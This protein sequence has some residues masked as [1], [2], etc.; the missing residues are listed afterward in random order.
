[1]A[2]SKLRNFLFASI[3]PSALAIFRIVFGAFM[4][5]QTIYYL[6]IDYARQFMSGPEFLF[7]YEGLA[8]IKP[9]SYGI[10]KAIN[11]GMI[12]AA[13]LIGLGFLYRWASIFFFLGFSYFTL[14]DKTIYNNHLYL[15]ML[16]ALVMIF[17]RADEKYS[18]KRIIK[19]SSV[20]AIPAWNQYLLAFLIGLPYFFGGIAK[21]SPNWLQTDLVNQIVSKTQDTFITGIFSD[22]ILIPFFKY[23]GLVYDLGI[24]FL[25]CFRKTRWFAFGLVVLFNLTNHAVLFN[26]IGLF[27]FLMIFSTVLFFDGARL[28]AYLDKLLA[29]LK[30]SGVSELQ[31]STS[32][33]AGNGLT[34]GLLLFFI[35]FQ[36]LFPL[37]HHLLTY[38]PEWTGVAQRFSWRMKLQSK[39][40]VVMQ[41]ELQDPTT[42]QVIPVD[43]QTFMTANQRIHFLEDPFNVVALAKYIKSKAEEQGVGKGLQLKADIQVIFNGKAIQPYIEPNKD[44]TAISNSKIGNDDW[45]KPLR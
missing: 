35:I 34:F 10:L 44:L 11:I 42:K 9:M 32:S 14:I 26:D 23:G 13:G 41:M 28:G 4:M 6:N 25:L 27:P 24:V 16:L 22:S 19:K 39:T 8:F 31:H 38:N 36:L 12:V 45:I 21:L 17:M 15:I 33:N 2:I 1:M 30:F 18:L 5:Y 7:A 3:D 37:R 43:V 29:K 20:K 40:P